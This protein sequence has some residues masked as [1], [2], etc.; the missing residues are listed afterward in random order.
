MPSELPL[1]GA[2]VAASQEFDQLLSELDE[3]AHQ[4]SRA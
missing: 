3:I 1:P 4:A 2:A